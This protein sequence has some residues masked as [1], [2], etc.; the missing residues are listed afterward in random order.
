MTWRSDTVRIL[1]CEDSR[2]YADALV[3]FIERDADLRVV[4][5][6]PD[7]RGLSEAIRRLRPDLL[8]MDLELP[9]MAGLDAVREV[10]ATNPLPILVLSAHTPRG[11]ELA[12]SALG[13]GAI[14][15]QPK[16][17][18][19]IDRADSP[20]ATAFRRRLKRLAYARVGRVPRIRRRVPPDLKGRVASVIAVGASTGGPPA[21]KTMLGRL[22]ADFPLPI[23]VAQ[24]ISS[25]FAAPFARWL[26]GAIALPVRMATDGARAGPGVWVAPDDGHLLLG[27][28]FRMKIDTT[29]SGGGVHRPSADVLLSSVAAN[30]GT[31]SAGVV[32]TGMGRDGA[33]GV[34]AIRA[35]G[36]FTI[37]QDESSSAIFGMPKAAAERGAELVLPLD[38]IGDALVRLPA[39]ASSR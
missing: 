21:L 4:G 30:A 26:D 29:A 33:E 5:R 11:S 19:R 6:L 12:T 7:A 36:G 34:A 14:D 31:R 2:S 35:A 8:T 3:D 38:E 27:R 24:H 23:L 39:G 28:G 37:A 10:M 18:L 16:H 13:A 1:I 32:L 25:G 20:S 22:P 15:V 9:G 17:E